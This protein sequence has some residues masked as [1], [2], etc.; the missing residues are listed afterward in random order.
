MKLADSFQKLSLTPQ[1]SHSQT[2]IS[3]LYPI[4]ADLI[5]V[6]QAFQDRVLTKQN[7]ATLAGI[8][9]MPAGERWM[10]WH[11]DQE[12]GLE[13]SPIFKKRVSLTHLGYE[14]HA[15]RDRKSVV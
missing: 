3:C 14:S 11:F 12:T 6:H 4:I 9:L 13:T 2:G 8:L 15:F 7:L 5:R 10:N 1:L